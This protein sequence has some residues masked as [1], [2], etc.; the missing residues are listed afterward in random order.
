MTLGRRSVIQSLPDNDSRFPEGYH[1][2]SP[3]NACSAAF[4]AAK[5]VAFSFSN[6]GYRFRKQAPRSA[7]TITTVLPHT[8]GPPGRCI[9]RLGMVVS[10]P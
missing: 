5:N 3:Q 2:F 6:V 9:P 4:V 8:P 7:F 1:A 10:D